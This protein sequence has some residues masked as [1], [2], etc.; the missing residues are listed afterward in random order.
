MYLCKMY[1]VFCT[2]LFSLIRINN[3]KDVSAINPQ[4]AV[5]C[6]LLHTCGSFHTMIQLASVIPSNL[7]TDTLIVD[8]EVSSTIETPDCA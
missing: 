3:N 8:E 7:S 4:V 2:L 6:T 1:N 5:I